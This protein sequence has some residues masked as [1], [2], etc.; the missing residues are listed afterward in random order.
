VEKV[1]I[2]PGSFKGALTAQQAADI[3][4]GEVSAAFPDCVIVSLPI[5]GLGECNVDMIIPKTGGKIYEAQVISPDDRQITANYGITAY[6]TAIIEMSQSSGITRQIGYHPMT[7]STYGL[8]QTIMSAIQWGARDFVICPR[9]GA[10]TD[11]GCGMAAALGVR[12]IDEQGNSFIPCGDTL[13]K[14]VSI[15][16]SG[17][18]M[19]TTW[20]KFT[21][22]HDVE[23]PLFGINGAA[24][25]DGPKKGADPEQVK[26]LDEGLRHL[27]TLLYEC[28]GKDYANIPGAG[29]GGG[30]GAG[31]MALLG[32]NLVNRTEV[33]IKLCG[34]KK[35]IAHADLIITGEGKLD[36]HSFHG[37]I[38]SCILR[39][40][41]KVPVWSICGVC[42][43]N[44]ALMC[45]HN[46][47]VFETREGISIEESMNKP[48]KYLRNTARKAVQ[49]MK[50]FSQDF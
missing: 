24:H 12:F 18:D 25:V 29:A 47:I 13:G 8:G 31:C 20:S 45:K 16:T 38:L 14:I 50:F 1:V 36:T 22:L 35:K 28:F 10:T 39:D 48:A 23:T 15:D 32:A 40:A 5:H 41:G 7:S 6:G 4:A 43:Y 3:I 34:F 49:Y 26:K 19:R 9:D 46:L 42:E 2:A 33:M 11:G 37:R 17:I 27:G 30:L 44:E 21:I